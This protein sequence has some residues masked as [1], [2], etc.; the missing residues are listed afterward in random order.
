MNL[1]GSEVRGAGVD[2]VG[3]H[4]EQGVAHRLHWLVRQDRE[5]IPLTRNISRSV[6]LGFSPISVFFRD[7]TR[8]QI[9]FPGEKHV[10]ITHSCGGSLYSELQFQLRV[11]V[12]INISQFT[13]CEA[14]IFKT[15]Y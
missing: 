6:K 8:I 2:Q 12:S 3:E 5:V 7:R 4:Q 14:S 13:T 9:I 11:T 1:I 10:A 15:G